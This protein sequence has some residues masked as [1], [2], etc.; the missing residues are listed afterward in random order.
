MLKF[1]SFLSS[2]EAEDKALD[3]RA[4][5]V[6]A[7]SVGS[8]ASSL[9]RWR[10]VEGEAGP[11]GGAKC[12]QPCSLSSSPSHLVTFSPSLG[13]EQNRSPGPAGTGLCSGSLFPLLPLLGLE[14]LQQGVW[15]PCAWWALCSA[16]KC[17]HFGPDSGSQ[18]G[19][20]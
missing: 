3:R 5:G 8:A 13:A 10:W 18:L 14:P 11:V 4:A 9:G 15:G 17:Q 1:L 20:I 12:P 7:T 6:L 2:Q 19:G 16:E